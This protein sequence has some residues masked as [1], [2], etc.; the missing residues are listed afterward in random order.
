[1]RGD[2]ERDLDER[3]TRDPEWHLESPKG[4]RDLPSL[5]LEEIFKMLTFKERHVCSQ[6]CLNWYVNG[7]CFCLWF[8]MCLEIYQ[9]P[10]KFQYNKNEQ[11]IKY[12]ILTP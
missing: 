3:R 10:N 8:V 9:N 2:M 11:Q 1:M 6:V 5:L 4:W 12:W 7:T